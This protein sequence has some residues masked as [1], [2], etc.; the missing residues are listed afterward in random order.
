MSISLVMHKTTYAGQEEVTKKMVC[1]S[2]EEAI[3]YAVAF[4]K[5]IS[6]RYEDEQF[7]DVSIDYFTDTITNMDNMWQDIMNHKGVVL[8]GE[9]EC[10]IILQLDGTSWRGY[11]ILGTIIISCPEKK[12]EYIEKRRK[13]RL[14]A[15]GRYCYC[16]SPD[17]DWDCGTLPCRCIDACRLFCDGY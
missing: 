3:P 6:G 7:R 12:K 1:Y 17:C 10:E 15:Y 4:M 16:G 14:E 5:S 9:K 11:P 2:Y 8:A 13:E